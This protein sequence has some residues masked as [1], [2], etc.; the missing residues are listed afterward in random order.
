[1]IYCLSYFIDFHWYIIYSPSFGG[2]WYN[3]ARRFTASTG[4]A[5]LACVNPRT[6]RS[7]EAHWIF[8]KPEQNQTALWRHISFWMAHDDPW[9][10]YHTQ[11]DKSQTSRL[12]WRRDKKRN[13][14]LL[15]P[16]GSTT[17]I[18]IIIVQGTVQICPDT[19]HVRCLEN[20]CPNPL[21]NYKY[22]KAGARKRSILLRTQIHYG[23]S[24][25]CIQI[26]HA[27]LALPSNLQSW[28]PVVTCA[29]YK[30]L[31]QMAVCLAERPT[32]ASPRT[33]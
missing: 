9:W 26:Q 21:S 12:R 22:F 8:M 11:S 18:L 2:M 7:K 13:A 16:N 30:I 1:M 15:A 6:T 28:V 25:S 4:I 20:V 19:V 17:A 29:V 24:S 32:W 14:K 27:P 3:E 31:C 10:H 33:S 23:V 5:T